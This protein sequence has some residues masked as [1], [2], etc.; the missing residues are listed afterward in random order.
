L[1]IGGTWRLKLGA[2]HQPVDPFDEGRFEPEL[3]H[4]LQ[5]AALVDPPE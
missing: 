1:A 3:G 4:L 5:G 2:C